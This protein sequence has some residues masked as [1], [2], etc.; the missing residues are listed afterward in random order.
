MKLT[1]VAI[2]PPNA[3]LSETDAE[4]MAMRVARSEGLYQKQR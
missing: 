2:N 3:P 4:K 1:P